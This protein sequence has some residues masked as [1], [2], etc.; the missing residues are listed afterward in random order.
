MATRVL[1][2]IGKG[3][4]TIPQEWRAALGFEEKAVKAT[5]QGTK[6]VIEPLPLDE[7]RRWR[8][9]Q[10][11]LNKLSPTDKKVILAGRRAYKKGRKEKFLTSLE[12]FKN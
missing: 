4:I 8:V 3:Q 11:A 10:I 12:F 6:I 9:E 7:E 2:F 5:L 1:Q